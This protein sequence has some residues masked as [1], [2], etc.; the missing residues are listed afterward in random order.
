MHNRSMFQRTLTTT[1]LS[2]SALLSV[3][4]DVAQAPEAPSFH[5]TNNL[6]YALLGL[7]VVQVIFIISWPG[8]CAPWAV[9]ATG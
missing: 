8:S 7:A 6:L 4:Q 3:A 5:V 9:R 1:L 2:A